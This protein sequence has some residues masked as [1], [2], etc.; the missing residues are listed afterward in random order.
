MKWTGERLV[1]H[2]NEYYT[3]EHLHRY[4]LAMEYVTDQVVLDI[5]SG[6]G[7]GTALLAKLAKQAI[8]ADIDQESVTH[9]NAKYG[10]PNLSFEVADIRNL[11]FE[12]DSFSVVTCFET[13]EHITEHELV[14]SELKRVLRSNGVLILST[15]DKES[16][17]HLASKGANPFHLKE[18]GRSDFSK[19]T[20]SFFKNVKLLYQKSINASVIIPEVV[21]R[22]VFLE[23][24]G[25][26]ESYVEKQASFNAQYLI[27]ICS[28]VTLSEQ[29]GNSILTYDS[30]RKSLL[31]KLIFKIRNSFK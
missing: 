16:D 28:D 15:P 11:P 10:R 19:L 5:A 3:Y 1:T 9:A 31:E 23:Y 22:E 18:L 17:H 21:E 25:D 7:Y 8:G 27:G 13:L 4:Y 14:M 26:F 29:M 12:D 30:T 6:E 2:V 20:L 24:Q